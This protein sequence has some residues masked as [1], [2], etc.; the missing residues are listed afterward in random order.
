[1]ICIF[2]LNFCLFCL[3]LPMIECTLSFKFPCIPCAICSCLFFIYKY[4]LNRRCSKGWCVHNYLCTHN[5]KKQYNWFQKHVYWFKQTIESDHVQ[6]ILIA[7]VV[8]GLNDNDKTNMFGFKRCLIELII[9]T[10]K[11]VFK[12]TIILEQMKHFVEFL[13]WKLKYAILVK[14][15]LKNF[16]PEFT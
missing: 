7:A 3:F 1:M 10:C 6:L 12:Q 11:Q 8:Q 15:I 9:I 5:Y 14:K 2:V 13:K 4:S 16:G